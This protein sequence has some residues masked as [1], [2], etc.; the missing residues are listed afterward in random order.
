MK[1]FVQL[2]RER[3]TKDLCQKRKVGLEIEFP[4]VY[5]DGSIFETE[6]LFSLLVEDEWSPLYDDN[7]NTL[8]VGTERDN[9]KVLSEAGIGVLE[10]CF[11]PSESLFESWK[12]YHLLLSYLSELISSEGG[13]ILGYGIQPA[14]FNLSW[15]KK[16]RYRILRKTLPPAVNKITLTAASQVHIEVAP[17][18]V[19]PALNVFNALSGVMI[20]FF[21]NS[22]VFHRSLLADDFRR[23][24]AFREMVWDE[25][26]PE[27]SGVPPKKFLDLEEYLS[28][29]FEME[30]ILCK[31]DDR[32]FSPSEPFNSFV[33]GTDIEKVFFFYFPWH[34]GTIWWNARSRASYGTVEVRSACC[35]PHKNALTVAAF[36]LGVVENL[37][38]VY[39]FLFDDLKDVKWYD[40]RSLRRESA[41]NGFNTRLKGIGIELVGQQILF[42]AEQGL[43]KRGKGEESF[44]LPLWERLSERKSPAETAFYLFNKRADVSSLIEEFSY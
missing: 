1:E 11:N 20:A 17:D 30:F 43:K 35:Q 36:C 12:A 22:S 3:F 38:R 40:W 16:E 8:L 9:V 18:E 33:K 14:T 4:L 26:A 39:E 5:P 37:R 31:E 25:F 27:R 29:L 21:A 24:L 32:F 28:Y 19:I 44:L 10:V 34:E 42:L 6:K 13:V 15:S 2:Y 7:S 23:T 41:R